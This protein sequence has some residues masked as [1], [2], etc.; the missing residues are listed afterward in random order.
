M[1]TNKS[2]REL[3]KMFPFMT[4][5]EIK[6]KNENNTYKTERGIL[7][8]LAK[9]NTEYEK[10]ATMPKVK[11]LEIEIVW[12]KNRTWGVIPHASMSWE[13]T[14]GWHYEENAAIASGWGYDKSSSVVAERFNKVCSG[15]LWNKRRSRK[16]V[17]YGIYFRGYFPYFEGGVGM[18]CYP[19]IAAF[20]GG[21]MEHVADTKTYDKY[22]FTFK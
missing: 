9:I 15:M 2:L 14:N 21:K 8:F 3:K 18:G 20:L 11:R 4:E 10:R 5:N 7:N 17:P 13:D 1:K 16:K 19:S 22:V 6:Y 12:V